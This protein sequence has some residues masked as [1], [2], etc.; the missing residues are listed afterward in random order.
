MESDANFWDVC[1]DDAVPPKS[2]PEGTEV[3]LRI[4]E[5]S[6]N[7]GKSYILLILKPQNVEGFVRSIRHFLFF[8]KADD[9]E[10]KKNNKKLALKAFTMCFDTIWPI[11]HPDDL[12]GHTGWV[13]LTEKEDNRGPQFGNIN[14]IKQMLARR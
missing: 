5:V 9:N 10:E 6:P 3:E 12:V 14:E 7:A 2:L 4:D 13:I 1:I 11:T 8:P